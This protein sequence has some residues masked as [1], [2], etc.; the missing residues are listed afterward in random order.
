MDASVVIVSKWFLNS[1]EFS[2]CISIS[3]N[4]LKTQ[5]SKRKKNNNKLLF[6]IKEEKKT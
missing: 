5:S 3:I 1:P 2:H 6:I 4:A